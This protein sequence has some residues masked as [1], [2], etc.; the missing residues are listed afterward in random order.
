MF[1]E[2]FIVSEIYWDKYVFCVCIAFRCS[3]TIN[4]HQVL[5]KKSDINSY[6][7]NE[8]FL[9]YLVGRIYLRKARISEVNNEVNNTYHYYKRAVIHAPGIMHNSAHFVVKSLTVEITFRRFI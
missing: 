9:K 3:S 7:I 5:Q 2:V 4:G 6:D 8:I 1:F